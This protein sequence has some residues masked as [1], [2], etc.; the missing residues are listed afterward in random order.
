MENITIRQ[1]LLKNH[2]SLSADKTNWFAISPE[3]AKSYKTTQIK[4]YN[5]E[6]TYRHIEISEDMIMDIATDYFLFA[7][8]IKTFE[9]QQETTFQFHFQSK[10]GLGTINLTRYMLIQG[11]EHILSDPKHIE[12]VPQL[13]YVYDQILA[14]SSLDS[15]AEMYQETV[16]YDIDGKPTTFNPQ[17]FFNLLKL[18]NDDFNFF[19]QNYDPTTMGMPLEHFLYGFS[20]FTFDQ[21]I[22][23]K[24]YLDECQL[25]RYQQICDHNIVDFESIN[26]IPKTDNQFLDRTHI[27]PALQEEILK[28]MPADYTDLQK[29]QY[30]YLKL[31]QT[32][33][34]DTEFYAV[35]QSGPR[36]NKHKKIDYISNITP[37]NNQAVCYE[38]AAI[39]GKLLSIAAPN[40]THD[41]IF[42]S[43][44]FGHEIYGEDHVYTEFRCGKFM[45]SADTV[46]GIFT[47]DM[48]QQKLGK[49]VNGIKCLNQ[50]KETMR[51]FS[52]SLK[53]VKQDLQ[54]Q[55]QSKLEGQIPT[56][57]DEAIEMYRQETEDEQVYIDIPTR[58]NFCFS[59][60][61]DSQLTGLDAYSYLLQLR[62]V[63]FDKKEQTENVAIHILREG[64]DETELPI[65][66]AAII[67]LSNNYR[68]ENEECSYIVYKPQTG[69]Q[70]ISRENLMN[71]FNNG[72]YSYISQKDE[73]V[74][75]INAP[76]CEHFILNKTLE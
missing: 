18:S 59:Q 57:F 68:D 2:P 14:I 76:V 21:K 62:K 45:V 1:S 13:N 58:L 15:L 51:E 55:T 19:V 16:T 71:A 10:Y 17:S 32:L 9:N 22:Y 3:K 34:Y 4:A 39:Y 53:T 43:S 63:A 28:D 66:L 37:D 50:S 8:I 72:F 69:P 24:S 74:P 7:Y 33:T 11:L 49:P 65:D 61:K 67:T 44:Y 41:L 5:P 52:E 12:M 73:A 75:G 25:S 6:N 60:L 30:I 48:T 29:A 23:L 27:N 40:T 46:A 56:S 64:T 70:D 54:L 26:Y 42:R 31:C 47:S 36:I 20:Q 38:I 35:N